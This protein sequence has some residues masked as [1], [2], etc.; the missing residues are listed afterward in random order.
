M[1]SCGSIQLT[2]K[3]ARPRS[4]RVFVVELR[5]LEPLTPTLPGMGEGPEQARY[6]AR[7][8]VVGV[9]RRVAVVSVVVRFVVNRPTKRRI[10]NRTAQN[11]SGDWSRRNGEISR[12]D[13]V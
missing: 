4:E 12:V 7:T 11:E 3:P 10:R 9:A 2:K 13:A 5:G 8:C 6:G 1:A